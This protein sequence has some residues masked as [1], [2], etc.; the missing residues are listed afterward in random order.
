MFCSQYMSI[1]CSLIHLWPRISART[2]LEKPKLSTFCHCGNLSSTKC[3]CRSKLSI[4]SFP[5]KSWLARLCGQLD[6]QGY[7]DTYVRFIYNVNFVCQFSMLIYISQTRHL[8]LLRTI[9]R[10]VIN[11]FF[12]F[13]IYIYIYISISTSIS[14]SISISIY[15]SLYIYIYA[16][17]N[18]LSAPYQ[19]CSLK[20][21]EVSVKFE[22]LS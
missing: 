19:K 8:L 5:D 10:E 18:I 21:L 15:L 4:I 3:F 11:V 22:N 7:K 1:I 2:F 20:K 13:N 6:D 17:F 12:I 16:L 14:I 9:T